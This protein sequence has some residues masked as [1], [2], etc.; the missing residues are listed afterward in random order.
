M[1]EIYNQIAYGKNKYGLKKQDFEDNAEEIL[2][3]RGH[4]S[5]VANKLISFSV[6]SYFLYY[7]I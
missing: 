6:L 4:F 3:D 5:L 7:E 2:D 1:V